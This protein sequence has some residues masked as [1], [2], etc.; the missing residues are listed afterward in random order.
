MQSIY[1]I[2]SLRNYQASTYLD[3]LRGLAAIEVFVG[4]FRNLFFV[5]REEIINKSFLTDALYLITGFGH[6][7]VM[8][9]FVLSGFFISSSIF[10]A[11]SI[12]R[13][14]WKIYLVN[15]LSRLEVVLI[16]ALILTYFWDSLGIFIFGVDGV[17]GGNGLGSNVSNY[18]IADR[19]HPS[20]L[21]GNLLFFQNIFSITFGSNGALWSLANEW[22]YYVTFPLVLS[23]LKFRSNKKNIKKMLASASLPAIPNS[24]R[25]QDLSAVGVFSI[26]L[27]LNEKTR[28]SATKKFEFGIAASLLSI[29][30]YFLFK[31]D[32]IYGFP[33]WLMGTTI[34]LLPTATFLKNSKTLHQL[35]IV[36]SSLVLIASL[37]MTRIQLIQN[38]FTPD[39]LVGIAS[40]LLIYSLLN[41]TSIY[42]KSAYSEI[43]GFLSKISYS[44]YVTHLPILLFIKA[45]AIAK[46]RWQPDLI[47]ILFGIFIL[48]ATFAYAFIIYSWTEAKTDIVR[49]NILNYLKITKI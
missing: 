38:D 49:S 3:L 41:D 45:I 21:L 33:V 19:L 22:W 4:H 2:N 30:L 6:Q 35:A 47:H 34:C 17:Y 27:D 9:F 16:P 20:I 1:K 28:V 7:A 31:S 40:S 44:L 10:K 13:W 43:T 25:V 12:E 48:V 39:L 18:N 14:S 32:I 37:L 26:D 11:Y 24:E 8:I 23:L 36:G 42:T 29:I 5:D 15:R 46:M